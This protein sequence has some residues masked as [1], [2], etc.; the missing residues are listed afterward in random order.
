MS[1]RV[2]TTA[3]VLPV[4]II[5]FLVS[6]V[7]FPPPPGPAPTN[8]ELAL[9]LVLRAFDS[10]LLGIG[11]AFAVFGWP[12]VRRVAPDSRARA[13]AMFLAVAWITISWYPH[14][15]LHGS[16]FGATLGGT[17]VIDYLFHLPLYLVGLAL[18]WGVLGYL[19]NRARPPAPA[20][21]ASR[22]AGTGQA[23]G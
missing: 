17:L 23:D 16:A 15:G 22:L 9:L 2:K 19:H 14:I 4:A 11:V 3:V 21:P 18:I 10:L 7:L 8:I 13:A 20:H 12:L 1:A 5:A 6:P